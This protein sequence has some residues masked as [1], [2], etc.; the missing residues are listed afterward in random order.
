MKFWRALHYGSRARQRPR[1]HQ[2]RIHVRGGDGAKKSIEQAE[3]CCKKAADLGVLE[4]FSRFVNPHANVEKP[5]LGSANHLVNAVCSSTNRISL[6][7]QKTS[8][9]S[10]QGVISDRTPCAMR[11]IPRARG[12]FSGRDT[13]WI[14]CLSYRD[15]TELPI[16]R[17]TL[18]RT[19]SSS[20]F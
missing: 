19:V 5:A 18:A 6:S 4:A 10:A 8:V 11:S 7:N 1:I 14:M 15:I 13:D 9:H 16:P 17:E 2:P 12:F 20:Q 3:M